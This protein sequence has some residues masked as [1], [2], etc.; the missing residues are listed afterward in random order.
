MALLTRG[1]LTDLDSMFNRILIVGSPAAGKTTFSKSLSTKLDIPSY[2]LDDYFWNAEWVPS[3]TS[4]WDEKLKKILN[5]PTWIIEGSYMDSYATRLDYADAVLFL[6]VHPLLCLY[7]LIRRQLRWSFRKGLDTLPMHV[8]EGKITGNIKGLKVLIPLIFNYRKRYK[9]VIV[10]QAKSK[11]IKLF[12]VS[13]V[14][15]FLSIFC[16]TKSNFKILVD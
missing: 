15:K 11:G 4:D 1:R 8:R 12:E 3:N 16:Q 10:E 14:S 9:K 5:T 13:N 7:R 6:D 2:S